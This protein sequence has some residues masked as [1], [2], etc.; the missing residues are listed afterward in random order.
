[1]RITDYGTVRGRAGY[2]MG[3]FMTYVMMAAA[4]GRADLFRSATVSGT[5]VIPTDPPIVTPFLFTESEQDNKSFI[6]GWA[7]GAG[8]DFMVMP[9]IFLRGEYEYV[10][11]A[12]KWDI[13]A[14][15]QTGRMGLGVKF[16]VDGVYL[17]PYSRPRDTPPHRGA[18]IWKDRHDGEYARRTPARAA[19]LLRPLRQAPR[20]ERPKSQGR[21]SRALAPSKDRQGE[22]QARHRAHARG[23]G[24]PRGLSHRYRP[25]VRYRRR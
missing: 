25:R 11:F 3:N 10:S 13:Q 7:V 23:A 2:E 4:F 1:M 8:F 15:I 14:Q 19:F 22:A 21:S 17:L 16:W 18:P 24:S 12:P 6:Y 5:E 9:G 20:L